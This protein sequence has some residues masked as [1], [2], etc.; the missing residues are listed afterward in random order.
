MSTSTN[1]ASA[2]VQRKISTKDMVL[3]AIFTTLIIIGTFV[4]IPTPIIPIT[5]QVMFTTLAGLIL[6]SRRGGLAVLL[7]VLLGLAGVPVFAGGGG[8]GYV[9]SPTFGYL[10]AFIIG[11]YVAGKMV[12]KDESNSI[13]KYAIASTVNLIIIYAVG[14]IYLYLMKN[15]YLAAPLSFGKALWVGMI[16][17]LPSDILGLLIACL[18]AVRIRPVVKKYL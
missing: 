6:G 13:K 17:P 12:E 14:V 3:C 1:T 15:F 7:Y 11:A 8:I 2:N 10:V 16:A 18:I 4:R 5:F 9:F